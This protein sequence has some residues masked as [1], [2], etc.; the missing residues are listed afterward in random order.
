MYNYQFAGAKDIFYALIQTETPY[1]QPNPNSEQPFPV[2]AKF[3]DPDFSACTTD[4]CKSAWGLRIVDSS[5]IWGYGSGTYSFFSNYDQDCLADQSCQENMISVENSSNVN[6]FGISTKA[7]VNM[8]VQ[9]G[10]SMALDADNRSNFCA[11]LGM[12]TIA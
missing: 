2:N 11:T 5:S 1:M 6:M 12:F 4:A 7:S 10:T 8:I 9:D 3:S